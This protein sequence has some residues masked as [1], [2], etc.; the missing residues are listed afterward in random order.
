MKNGHVFTA[1]TILIGL[2]TAQVPAGNE[3][4]LRTMVKTVLEQNRQLILQNNRLQQMWT[5]MRQIC[6]AVSIQTCDCGNNTGGS[7]TP[8]GEFI[9]TLTTAEP[10]PEVPEGPDPLRILNISTTAGPKGSDTVKISVGYAGSPQHTTEWIGLRQNGGMW[11]TSGKRTSSSENNYTFFSDVTIDDLSNMRNLFFRLYNDDESLNMRV[12]MNETSKN[13]T[14]VVTQPTADYL[15]VN[16]TVKAAQDLDLKIPA[17]LVQDPTEVDQLAYAEVFFT[18]LNTSASP[19][20]IFEIMHFNSEGLGLSLTKRTN[21]TSNLEIVLRKDYA[22][23]GGI[24]TIRL[25]YRNTVGGLVE[26]FYYGPFVKVLAPGDDSV[27]LP[28]TIGVFPL[29]RQ[30]IVFPPTQT[31]ICAAM[32]NPRPEVSILKVANGDARPVPLETVI[33]D[34]SMNMVVHSF[35]AADPAN[36]DGRYICRA[37]NGN[38]TIDAPTEVL[39]LRAAR[40]SA[41]RTGVMQNSTDRVVISCQASGRPRPALE[42]RLYDDYGPDL[43]SSGLY[44]V[45]K[46]DPNANTSR[47]TLTLTPVDDVDVHTLYCVANQGGSGGSYSVSSKIEIY[48]GQ[49]RS[50]NTE[51]YSRLRE[52]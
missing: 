48:P 16:T 44:K 21:T 29:S 4:E 12:N 35:K 24:L 3:A 15:T 42:L 31:M 9:Q 40:F 1:C 13:Q 6:E 18:G 28:N 51:L 25:P 43:V 38:Q 11:R 2:V 23:Y 14:H 34:S 36:T 47:V 22:Q 33:L 46:S 41:E 32:G 50:N 20:A 52:A 39:V 26:E 7:S 19:P 45:W 5:G 10:L 30:I 27:V 17:V 37:T 49:Q 8:S